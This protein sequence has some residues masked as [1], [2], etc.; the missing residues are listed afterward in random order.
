MIKVQNSVDRVL[1]DFDRRRAQTH[2]NATTWSTDVWRVHRGTVTLGWVRYTLRRSA[3]YALYSDGTNAGGQQAWLRSFDT[4]QSA[5][6]WAVQH[7]DK[8][9]IHR[10]T[11]GPSIIGHRAAG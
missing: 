7:A 4:F 10:R 8:I 2:P 11:L 9:V 5:V 1:V 3:L 6:A